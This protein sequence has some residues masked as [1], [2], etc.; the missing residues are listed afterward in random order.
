MAATLIAMC[1]G[2]G[3]VLPWGSDRALID[4]E[5]VGGVIWGLAYGDADNACAVV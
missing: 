1:G 3:V 4:V 5:G 2:G